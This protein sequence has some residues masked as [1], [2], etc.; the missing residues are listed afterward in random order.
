MNS[1]LKAWATRYYYTG[2]GKE[3]ND[4]AIRSLEER[5]DAV[6]AQYQK[7]FVNPLSKMMGC[8][9]NDDMIK[10]A[11]MVFGN[12]GCTVWPYVLNYW[13]DNGYFKASD[14]FSNSIHNCVEH[15]A[16]DHKLM[17]AT[18]GI[19]HS[20]FVVFTNKQNKP[21]GEFPCRVFCYIGVSAKKGGHT[22]KELADKPPLSL[23]N[24]QQILLKKA[25][26]FGLLQEKHLK[27]DTVNIPVANGL[28][29]PREVNAC[30]QGLP[31]NEVNQLLSALPPAMVAE[32]PTIYFALKDYVKDKTHSQIIDKY[33][34]SI[35]DHFLVGAKLDYGHVTAE[36]VKAYLD[37]YYG[38][39]VDDLSQLSVNPVIVA[40][41]DY[42]DKNVSELM[43]AMQ[44]SE[45]STVFAGTLDEAIAQYCTQENIDPRC[46]IQQLI[47]YINYDIQIN[48]WSPELTAE[49]VCAWLKASNKFDD[50]FYSVLNSI[51][52]NKAEFNKTLEEYVDTQKA[53]TMYIKEAN[54]I[55]EEYKDEMLE[56][57]ES[58]MTAPSA[59]E[60]RQNEIAI[61]EDYIGRLGLPN[62]MF[63]A[64]T[65]AVKSG[66][67][68][69]IKAYIPENKV[70]DKI[71]AVIDTLER[72]HLPKGLE[73]AITKA[74]ENH[75]TVELPLA[76]KEPEKK[77]DYNEPGYVAGEYLLRK[78]RESISAD[79]DMQ[80]RQKYVPV[81]YCYLRLLM[82]DVVN[83]HKD[84]VEAMEDQKAKATPEVATLISDAISKF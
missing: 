41:A 25:L 58:G 45:D 77:P 66:E 75:K 3:A 59:A 63:I 55:P 39:H 16:K 22:L 5:A 36:D 18:T 13:L 30:S 35:S 42:A 48:P 21:V 47:D 31:P 29:E 54:N 8:E 78:T 60:I 64:I 27:T 12:A 44:D 7:A 53:A 9:I 62:D 82:G 68:F 19:N 50:D 49:M 67:T 34:E 10:Q 69:N 72:I 56:A 38:I 28:V 37:N 2:L 32:Y 65:N 76:F 61:V 52:L 17:Y 46:T 74:I 1:L 11:L 51:I 70:A 79:A 84:I 40:D 33:L 81:L 43:S 15:F 14:S 83:E 57:V 73:N 23:N 24:S 80:N 20:D 4:D 71:N 6:E 26:E